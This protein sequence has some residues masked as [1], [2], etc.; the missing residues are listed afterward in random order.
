MVNVMEAL[1]EIRTL[2][3]QFASE[4]LRPHVERWDHERTIDG[5]A[6]AQLAE[7]GFFGMRIPEAFGGMEFDLPTCTAAL[8]ELA[9]GEPGVALLVA[10][11]AIAADIVL[12][13]GSD[14]QKRRWLERFASGDV[15][16][17]T[18]FGG[19]AAATDVVAREEGGGWG[20]HGTASFVVNG[21]SA[22]LCLVRAA[23]DG[24][25]DERLFLVPTGTTGYTVSGR[26]ATLGF[27]TLDIVN[28]TFDGVRVDHEAALPDAPAASVADGTDLGRLSV[29]AIALGI[30]QA[31]LDHALAYAAERQQFGQTL[32]S[33]EGIQHKLADM[34]IRVHAARAL[35][36]TAAAAPDA[37]ATAIAKVVASEVA[38]EVATEAVQIFGGYGYMRDY[39]VEKL[40]RDAKGTEIMEGANLRLRGVIAARLYAEDGEGGG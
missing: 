11:S 7:L 38:M 2:A 35:V 26:D 24:G 8:E 28:V 32:R 1:R 10:R 19:D 39:P 14:E 27:R 18:A 20:L 15:V 25:R 23:L 21:R 6:I 16:G 29:A 30:A 12:R 22:D 4:Q 13:H 17:C 31:A 5:D 3:R 9:W 37:L 40:M 34:T 33:F 36:A